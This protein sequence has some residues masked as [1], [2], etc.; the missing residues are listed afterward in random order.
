MSKS[1]K[2]SG[3][4]L[5]EVEILGVRHLENDGKVGDKVKKT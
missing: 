4:L 3:R 1:E 5:A 2:S